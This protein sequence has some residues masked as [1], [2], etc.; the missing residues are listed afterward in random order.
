MQLTIE[1]PMLQYSILIV[2]QNTTYWQWEAPMESAADRSNRCG[3]H[4]HRLTPDTNGCATLAGKQQ[5]Q[6][7]LTSTNQP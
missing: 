1:C 2:Q 5:H 3:T 7:Q 4:V 6:H